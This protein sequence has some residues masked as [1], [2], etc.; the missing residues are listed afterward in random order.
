MSNVDSLAA[1]RGACE[2]VAPF[3]PAYA[4]LPIE[5]GFGWEPLRGTDFGR[6][7]LGLQVS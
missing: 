3:H 2:R 4:N 7:Y 1:L 5:E 6:M